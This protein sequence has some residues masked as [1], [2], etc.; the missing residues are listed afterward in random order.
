MEISLLR[1]VPSAGQETFLC[2]L[3]FIRLLVFFQL[4]Y[5]GLDKKSIN[6]LNSWV[7]INNQHR[8]TI[9]TGKELSCKQYAKWT[10][11]SPLSYKQYAKWTML[12]RIFLCTI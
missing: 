12:S 4:T 5:G 2:V 7:D 6:F 10:M 9:K 11:L 3:I 8:M 1:S